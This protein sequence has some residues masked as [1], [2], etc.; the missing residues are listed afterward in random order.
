[1][2][3]M[4][5][6][7][8]FVPWRRGNA[9]RIIRSGKTLPIAVGI[10]IVVAIFLKASKSSTAAFPVWVAS[11]LVRVGKTEASGMVTNIDLFGARGEIVDTQVIVY[12]PAGGLTN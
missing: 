6:N 5:F 2:R 11:A 8:R 10:L 9:Q 12:A 1:M 7:T 3:F 4:N